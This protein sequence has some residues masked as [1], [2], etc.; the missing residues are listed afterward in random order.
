MTHRTS[1]H[2]L[3][4]MFLSAFAL[5]LFSSSVAFAQTK[6]TIHPDPAIFEV[7]EGQVEALNIV[8]ENVKDLYGVDVRAHFD[9]KVVEA[10]SADPSKTTVQ[11]VP[12]T[13]VQP[14]FVVRNQVDNQK[15]TLEYVL[16]QTNPTPP[17]NGTGI[18]FTILLRGKTLGKTSA[19]VIDHVQ[20]SDRR[21]TTI[22]VTPQNG[23]ISVVQPKPPTPTPTSS[24]VPTLVITPPA[25][26]PTEIA[27][28]N[29]AP[30][31]PTP[32][33][34]NSNLLFDVLLLSIGGC[35]FVSAFIVLAIA[36]FVF[37]RRPARSANPPDQ[38]S[39]TQW[40]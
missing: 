9:P 28:Q 18:L 31:A 39:Q 29:T 11:L 14:D 26:A 8:I 34:S 6:A 19:F 32:G 13:F 35:G 20:F 30:S 1:Q 37:L 4:R 33:A 2:F 17:A 27:A 3:C 12:G 36:A 24:V 23:K 5:V 15:G 7:G 10:V 40:R 25:A 21:G 16:T 38:Y 22:A